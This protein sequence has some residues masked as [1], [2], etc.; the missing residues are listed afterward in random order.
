MVH[1]PKVKASPASPSVSI[2][3]LKGMDY[4]LLVS[5]FLAI[6]GVSLPTSQIKSDGRPLGRGEDAHGDPL[7]TEGSC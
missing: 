1:G 4:Q 2:W 5:G 7:G 6:G 3:V